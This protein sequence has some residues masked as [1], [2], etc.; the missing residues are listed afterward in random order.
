[1]VGTYSTHGKIRQ[2]M[3]NYNRKLEGKKLCGELGIAWSMILKWLLDLSS[4]R[5]HGLN[6]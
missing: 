4:V 2:R 3:Q 6:P 5:R 1:M